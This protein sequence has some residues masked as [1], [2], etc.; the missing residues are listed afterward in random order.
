MSRTQGRNSGSR[1]RTSYHK[2]PDRTIARRDFCVLRVGKGNSVYDDLSLKAPLN[3]R[4][5][6]TGSSALP[7]S[8]CRNAQEIMGRQWRVAQCGFEGEPRRR[9]LPRMNCREASFGGRPSP[10]R[11]YRYRL[12]SAKNKIP[13]FWPKPEGICGMIATSCL[14]PASSFS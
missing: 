10:A 11:S 3:R 4:R 6:A 14:L 7:T 5:I 2:A 9:T 12:T 13:R 1:L 8:E